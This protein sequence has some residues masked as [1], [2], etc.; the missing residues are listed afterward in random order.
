M[1]EAR[2]PPVLCDNLEGE[3]E[4]PKGVFFFFF[5]GNFVVGFDG[6]GEGVVTSNTRSAGPFARFS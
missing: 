5:G 4:G 1:Y 3:G 2:N 6:G